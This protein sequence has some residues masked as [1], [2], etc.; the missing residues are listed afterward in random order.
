MGGGFS[1]GGLISGLDSNSLISQIMQIERQPI[2]RVRDRIT[3]LERQR[4]ALRDLRTSLQTLRNRS[5]DFR[6]GVVFNKFATTSTEEKI[7]TATVRENPVLGSYAVEVVTLASATEAKGST[8]LGAGI[9]PNVALNDSGF[10]TDVTAGTFTING[11]QFTV[12]PA[13]QSLNDVLAAINGSSAGVT[14]TYDAGTDKVTFENTAAGN[15]SL[16]NFGADG[17]ESN[18]LSILNVRQATQSTGGNGSTVL[19][20]TRNLGSVSTSD[21]LDQVSFRNG[22]LTAGNFRI[23][24]VAIDI[25]PTTDS[26]ADVIGRINGSDAQVTASYDSATDSIRVVSKVLGSRTINFQSGTSNFLDVAG[27]S[28]AAQTAGVDAQFRV[29]NGPLQ[30]RNT[31]EVSD[32][33]GGITLTMTSVGTTTINVSNDDD[34]VVEQIQ[35]FL[36]AFNDA[37]SKVNELTGSSGSLRADGGIRSIESYLR[38]TVFSTVT[39]INGEYTNLSSIGI[40]TGSTFDAGAVSQLTLDRDA[41]LNAY[42]DN[43]AN[44]KNLFQN[45]GKTGVADSF[46]TFLDEV[47]KTTGFLNARV[48]SNGTVDQQIRAHQDQIRRLEERL[49]QRES[50]MRQQFGRLEQLSAGFQSQNAAIAGLATQM[51]LL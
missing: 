40:S 6:L 29:N 49:T 35:G 33:I 22:A 37:V 41:F 5:Q 3:A 8:S 42:N 48:R 32:A 50:R 15:T 46:F 20:S 13:T 38:N 28:A 51:R 10:A 12:D 36:T 23:N 47:T 26:L 17:D 39:G 11:V 45:D 30:T 1:V 14:A 43:P 16:V 4:T 31:N 25:D 9:N 18:F 34:A 44:V 7:A 2:Q 27:L 21:K 24:G 19:T